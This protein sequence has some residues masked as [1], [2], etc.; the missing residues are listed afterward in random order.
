[1]EYKVLANF[2]PFYCFQ[3]VVL[4]DAVLYRYSSP[5]TDEAL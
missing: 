3:R 1:M 4:S 5:G 2:L